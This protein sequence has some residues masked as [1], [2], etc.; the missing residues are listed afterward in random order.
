MIRIL[1]KKNSVFVSHSSVDVNIATDIY[2]HLKASGFNPWM[3]VKDIPAGANYAEI[4][5]QSLEAAAALIVVLTQSG[6]Q[7]QHV[8]REVNIAI[9]LGIPIFPLNLSGDNDFNASLPRDWKYWL[10]IVQIINCSDVNKASEILI[11]SFK[12]RNLQLENDSE[13][14]KIKTEIEEIPV[15]SFHDPEQILAEIEP[16]VL[17]FRHLSDIDPEDIDLVSIKTTLENHVAF[18]NKIAKYFPNDFRVIDI[19]NST[20]DIFHNLISQCNLLE[21]RY[22]NVEILL[23]VSR[24][25]GSAYANTYEGIWLFLKGRV[26]ESFTYFQQL[27][28]RDEVA[29]AYRAKLSLR[30]RSE[31]ELEF[32]R[33]NLTDLTPE[34]IVDEFQFSNEQVGDETNSFILNWDYWRL[35]TSLARYPENIK[36]QD[37]VMDEIE[38]LFELN[39]DYLKADSYFFSES[40]N[41]RWLKACIEMRRGNERRARFSLKGVR[42]S[43]THYFSSYD[44][45]RNQLK[46]YRSNCVGEGRKF[47]DE[48][49]TIAN[50][51]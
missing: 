28:L 49:I 1:V 27:K 39:K 17:W 22:K 50:L 44:F 15:Q 14:E 9:D 12:T 6:I 48:L 5:S 11:E 10:S 40:I 8:K 42:D 37:A 24:E 19:S 25:F 13:I 33:E 16:T 32:W 3:A 26:D 51:V 29:E 7:S 30:G 18:K 4:L 38:K 21:P 46:G 45:Q 43:D 2:S 35:A 20:L 36:R 41:F 31:R 34:E 47:F 23:K